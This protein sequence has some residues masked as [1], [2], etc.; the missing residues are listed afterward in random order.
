MT[1]LAVLGSTGSIGAS[2]LDVVAR[3]RDRYEVH[4]LAARSD[5]RRLLAQCIAH[6]PRLAIL[7]D[8]QAAAELAAALKANGLATRVEGGSDALTAAVRDPDAAVVDAGT[9]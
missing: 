7:E 5:H 3:H 9:R 1:G 2:T 6:R 8:P 4:T